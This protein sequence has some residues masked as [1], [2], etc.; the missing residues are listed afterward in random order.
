[1]SVS[2]KVVM[3]RIEEALTNFSRKFNFGRDIQVIMCYNY[4][5]N[6]QVMKV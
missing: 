3:V 2:K 5:E 1:M 4:L 6:I